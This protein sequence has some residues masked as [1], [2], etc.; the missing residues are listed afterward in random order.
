MDAELEDKTKRFLSKFTAF[1]RFLKHLRD[2]SHDMTDQKLGA[3]ALVC[4]GRYE[5]TTAESTRMPES[6]LP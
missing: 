6:I 2:Q 1:Q 5:V 3:F 4:H